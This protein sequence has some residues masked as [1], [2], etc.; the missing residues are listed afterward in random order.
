MQSS[1]FFASQQQLGRCDACCGDLHLLYLSSEEEVSRNGGWVAYR[2]C[3]GEQVRT[4][5]EH[6]SGWGAGQSLGLV[7]NWAQVDWNKVQY[8]IALGYSPWWVNRA[9][10]S[11]SFSGMFHFALHCAHSCMS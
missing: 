6:A 10:V 2:T 7:Q 9:P 1:I 8:M 4:G 3:F 5:A 11:S